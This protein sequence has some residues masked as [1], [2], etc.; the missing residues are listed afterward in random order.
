MAKEQRYEEKNNKWQWFLYVIV[1][2][3]VF[4]ITL[5]M[6]VTTIAGINPFQAM[7]EYGSKVPVVSSFINDPEEERLQE[8][9]ADYESTVQDQQATIHDLESQLST[10]DQEVDELT[11]EVNTLQQ[12]LE[13]QEHSRISQE[14]AVERLTRSFSEMVA[15]HAAD[16]IVEMEVEIAL[17]VLEKL[18]DD[19]RGEILSEMDS[20]IA[21]SFTNSLVQRSN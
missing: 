3:I 15:S 18:N 11:E 6:V 20:D 14:E 4:A 13:S 9:I 8:Q 16:I 21:A 10:R 7:Q 19:E 12:Q 2:P 1:I 5:V 17:D